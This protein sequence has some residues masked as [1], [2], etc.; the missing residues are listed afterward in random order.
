MTTIYELV[1]RDVWFGGRCVDVGCAGGRIA[2]IADAGTVPMRGQS[3]PVVTDQLVMTAPIEVHA[4]LDK[5]NTADLFQTAAGDLGDAIDAWTGAYDDRTVDEIARRARPVVVR[6]IDAGYQRIRTHVDCGPGIELRAVEALL[7]LRDAFAGTIDIEVCAM[8]SSPLDPRVLAWLD[9]ALT[10]GVDLVGGYPHVESDIRA[11]TEILLERAAG[12]GRPV[13]LHVDE[14][15]DPNV[16]G[17]ADLCDFASDFPHSITASHCCSLGMA[18]VAEQRDRAAAIAEADITVVA[19]PLT[20]LFLHARAERTAPPR[21]LAPVATLRE[22]GAR[23]VAGAD[24]LQD[25][26]HAMGRADPF[27][28]AATMVTVAHVDPVSAWE[29]VADDARAALGLEAVR[30]AVGS[31]ADF[32]VV[33]ASSVRAAIADA[34]ATRTVIRGGQVI[35]R[36]TT[37]TSRTSS[38]DGD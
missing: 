19:L 24:N 9:A 28:T 7:G 34:P 33:P 21:G 38:L 1:L 3:E 31:P 32:L 16:T 20:N 14:T 8:A 6:M 22:A 11:A 35:S 25:P 26:F 17:L 12:A 37:I 2:R 30:P 5:V 15:L 13:D 23:V 27:E 29:M 18:D 4:H 10:L 36:T